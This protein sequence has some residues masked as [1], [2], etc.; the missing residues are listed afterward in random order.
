MQPWNR[1]GDPGILSPAIFFSPA[2]FY[3]HYTRFTRDFHAFYMHLRVLHTFDMVKFYAFPAIILQLAC[4][5]V[6]V[7]LLA[8][9]YTVKWPL[10]FDVILKLIFIFKYL[11]LVAVYFKY[12]I[13]NK[14][15]LVKW[16]IFDSLS[17]FR[18]VALQMVL[19]GCRPFFVGC[20]PFFQAC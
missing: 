4:F 3:R 5:Y 17:I 7:K 8:I 14:F 2:I 18:C 13:L 19:A 10:D 9:L 6:M 20:R 12:F 15:F 11:L 1:P 16:G